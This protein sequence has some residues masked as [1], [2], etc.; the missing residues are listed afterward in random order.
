[1]W[2]HK[3]RLFRMRALRASHIRAVPRLLG[4]YSLNLACNFGEW[5]HKKNETRLPYVLFFIHTVLEESLKN[6]SHRG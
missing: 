1:M 4:L 6:R 5:R 2:A 3:Q